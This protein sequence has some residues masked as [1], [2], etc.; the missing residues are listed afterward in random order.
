[1]YACFG[2]CFCVFFHVFEF[3]CLYDAV[4]HRAGVPHAFAGPVVGKGQG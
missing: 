1:M 2:D 4:G 3:Y